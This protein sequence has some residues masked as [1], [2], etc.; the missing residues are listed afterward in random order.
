MIS[1]NIRSEKDAQLLQD[2][3]DRL[4]DWERMWM[5]EFN[6]DKCEA[7]SVTNKKNPIKYDYKIHGKTLK[8]VENTKYLGLTIDQKLS[9]NSH[10]DKISKKAN[11]T[12]SFLQRN[13]K[14]CPRHIKEKCYT[15]YVR[16]SLEYASSVWDPHTAKSINKLESVQRRAARYVCSDYNPESSPTA[17]LNQLNWPT[18][19]TRRQYGKATMMYRIVN[20]LVAIP[21][22]PNLKP[23]QSSTRGHDLRFCQPHTRVEAYKYSY[24]PSAIRLWNT[25]PK[26]LISQP[27][28]DSFKS[29]LS[30]VNIGA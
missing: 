8:N 15:T 20:N 10:I 19:Q 11:A 18:I 27:S 3:L 22:E 5:M 14:M 9:W 30:T 21:M 29:Y 17:M 25:L 13:T 7:I 1:R 16:P 6:P 12:R 23:S 2:D 28:I 24:F 26:D 4:Q